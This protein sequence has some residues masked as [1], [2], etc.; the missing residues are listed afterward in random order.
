MV[1]KINRLHTPQTHFV[2]TGW[3]CNVKNNSNKYNKRI[4]KIKQKHLK[5]KHFFVLNQ[6]FYVQKQLKTDS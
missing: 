1:C 4:V 6:T 5:C 2:K 3:W